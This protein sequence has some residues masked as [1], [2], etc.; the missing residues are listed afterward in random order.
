MSRNVRISFHNASEAPRVVRLEPWGR[1]FPIDVG[2]KLEIIARTGTSP[3]LRV[4]ESS[5][6]TLVWTEGCDTLCVVQDGVLNV[7][8]PTVAVAEPAAPPYV[9][10]DPMWD[11]DLDF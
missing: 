3:S 5:S 2:E 4:V 6:A 7:L 9:D 11:R 8:E 1:E 10:A